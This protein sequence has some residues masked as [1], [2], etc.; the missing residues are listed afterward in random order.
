[1]LFGA[2]AFIVVK[3]QDCVA[4]RPRDSIDATPQ[5]KQL[6]NIRVLRYGEQNDSARQ[7]GYAPYY[8]DDLQRLLWKGGKD[9]A[10]ARCLR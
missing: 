5:L 7:Y 6:N 9:K 8:V 4:L 10:V 1:M 2:F 3:G